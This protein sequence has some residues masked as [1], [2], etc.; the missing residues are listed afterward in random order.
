MS[1]R[2]LFNKYQRM[3]GQKGG[4]AFNILRPNYAAQDQ[5]GTLVLSNVMFRAA[6]QAN[7]VQEPTMSGATKYNVFGDRGNIQTGDILVPQESGSGTPI[8][9]IDTKAEMKA[10]TAFMT[11][12]LGQITKDIS[13]V[14]YDNIQFSFLPIT[15]PGS[16]LE[17]N[18]AGSLKI[19]TRKAILYN[20]TGI[21]RGMRL[22]EKNDSQPSN[23]Q[24]YSWVIQDL[25]TLHN[26][27]VLNL[28]LDD[29]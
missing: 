16:S 20:R 15:F 10:L 3:V 18:F 5:T 24:P 17:E 27:T 21:A 11:E 4:E 9:T 8:L 13:T 26:L 6:P 7:K 25:I 14:V 12:Q 22:I 1:Y 28:T 19:S 29:R 23:S 2:G